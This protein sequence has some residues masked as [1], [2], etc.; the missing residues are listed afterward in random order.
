ME[1]HN[2]LMPHWSFTLCCSEKGKGTRLL[3]S[4]RMLFSK[5]HRNCTTHVSS[6]LWFH[7]IILIPISAFVFW[8][9]HVD[10]NCLSSFRQRD[11]RGWEYFS[12]CHECARRK[13][14]W[15]TAIAK[16]HEGVYFR[17][18]LTPRDQRLTS[19]KWEGNDAKTIWLGIEPWNKDRQ[20]FLFL[21]MLLQTILACQDFAFRFECLL[22]WKQ[23]GSLALS[24]TETCWDSS[25]LRRKLCWV[26]DTGKKLGRNAVSIWGSNWGSST[27]NLEA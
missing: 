27:W 7:G 26:H 8:E 23:T 17:A 16:R 14:L 9:L 18:I 20:H 3:V 13:W 10:V 2:I 24:S 15:T 6:T 22:L 25:R 11:R 12:S 19:A 4:F 5:A 21:P 1:S